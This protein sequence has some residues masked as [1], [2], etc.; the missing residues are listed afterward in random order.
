METQYT[1]SDSKGKRHSTILQELQALKL[2]P[3]YQDEYFRLR[4]LL[5][6]LARSAQQDTEAMEKG[7]NREQSS[8]KSSP[9]EKEPEEQPKALSLDSESTQDEYGSDNS[10]VGNQTPLWTCNFDGELI[11]LQGFIKSQTEK[12][13]L[14]LVAVSDAISSPK[15]VHIISKTEDQVSKGSKSFCIQTGD[16]I[17]EHN[18]SNRKNNEACVTSHMRALTDSCDTIGTA[19]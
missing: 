9:W 5:N 11:R 16:G 18:T 15:K 6:L 14:Q 2:I 13:W 3:Q 10:H 17:A 7:N 19:C 1:A 8:N 12:L 4:T